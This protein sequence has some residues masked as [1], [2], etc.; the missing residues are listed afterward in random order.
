[1]DTGHFVIA[2]G[3]LAGA[4]AARTLRSE[5]FTG[6]ITIACAEAQVPYLRPPLSKEFLLGKDGED[7]VPVV[8]QDWY[9]ENGVDLL[10]GDPVVAA[11]PQA[12]TVRLGS[13]K[14][15]EYSK[16][17]IATG[18]QP[19]K[20]P[21]PGSELGGVGTFRTM[22]DSRR[23]KAALSDGGRRLVMVGSGW[24]GMEL[25]AAARSYGNEVTLLGLE[26]IPLSTAIGPELGA[27]FRGLHESHGV[28]F[29]LPASAKEI[30][31]SGG[32]A[33]AVVTDAG[34]EIPA[35]LVVIAAG[36]MPDTT[37]AGNAGLTLDDGIVVDASLRTSSPDVFAAGDV[38]NALHPFTGQHHRSEHWY[39][40]LMG[41]KVAAKAMLGQDAEL[42]MVPY[43]YTD[44]FDVAMEYSGFPSMAA[45]QA[46]VLRGS[47]DE[48]SFLA[49][50]LEGNAVVAGMSINRP[51]VHK[52]IKA[53]ISR[54][55]PV[56]SARL[57]DPEVPLEELLPEG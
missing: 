55:V 22:E 12:H 38:A 52:T 13:G 8:P 34:E 54:R 46:P 33:S 1:M 2:G 42:D 3:G 16:L 32:R 21:L 57:T 44:Q 51:K 53:L 19:R 28:K 45:G 40:A 56:D 31:G 41:G 18:A 29:R 14:E 27:F 10:L 43:F 39:N 50:W 24:I 7:K 15:L 37:L 17:L 9:A 49:F 48:K 23:L 20:L 47:M 25:A 35:D 11:D 36:V 26:D 4:T 5:G 6:T 30:K